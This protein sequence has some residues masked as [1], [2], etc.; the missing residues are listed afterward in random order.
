MIQTAAGTA[1][2]A[3]AKPYWGYVQTREFMELVT[4][5]EEARARAIT[6]TLICNTGKGKTYAVKKFRDNFPACTYVITINSLMTLGDIINE[7]LQ[8]LG[9]PERGNRAMRVRQCIMRLRE[10]R[11]SGYSPVLVLDEGENMTAETMRMLKGLYDGI[12]EDRHAGIVLIG[13]NQLLRKMERNRKRDGDA[14]PQFYRRFKAGIRLVRELPA[15]KAFTPFFEK[16]GITDKGLR[17]LLCGL[18][19]NY[20]ELNAYLEP[21]MREADERS[22]EL[23]ET[24]FRVMYNM[25]GD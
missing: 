8:Q 22:E 5:M 13:T 3:T 16:F 17:R 21:A 14:A 19:D 1:T 6:K 24:F 10:L 12:C 20:G 9:L 23:T 25:P 11:H 18:C 2:P 15:E 7:L 4:Q